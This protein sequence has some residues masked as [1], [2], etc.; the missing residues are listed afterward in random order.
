DDKASWDWA[1]FWRKP[2]LWSTHG[3][4]IARSVPFIPSL[5]GHALQDPSKSINTNYR[6]WEFQIYIYGLCLT[7]LWHILPER[8]WCNFCRLVASIC[9]LQHPCISQQELIYGHNLLMYFVCEFEELYYQCKESRIHFTQQFISKIIHLL[10]H[11]APE[12]FCIGPL[13]CYAQWMLETAIGNLGQEVQQDRNM[14]ANLAQRAVL[15]V[16]TNSLQACF[17]DILLNLGS[18]GTPSLS[19]RAYTFK[20]LEGYMLL[21][22][23]KEF[24]SPITDNEHDAL[25][26]YWHA[27]NWPN[28]DSWA[29]AVHCWASL[30]LPNGQR[31]HSS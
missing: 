29:N 3:E 19:S 24:P 22:C 11:I 5:F 4:T 14:F 9:L 28:T 2:K 17:P 13:A 16:Q 21:P 8:Y 10:T 23:S 30:Q 6:A 15:W 7:Q 1:I 12:T 31:A 20:G 18:N 25:G 26:L 27:Q